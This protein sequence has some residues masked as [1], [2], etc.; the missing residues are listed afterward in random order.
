MKNYFKTIVL[1]V[2]MLGLT[3][4]SAAKKVEVSVNKALNLVNISL[5]SVSVGER[6]V[7]KDFDGTSLFRK[8]FRQISNF[9]KSFSLKEVNNGMYFVE[10]ENDSQIQITPVLKNDL[11]VTLI[12]KAAKFIFKPQY[13]K[14]GD[15]FKFS[16]LNTNEEAIKI[17]MYTENG[18]EF[19]KEE[20]VNDLIIKRTYSTKELP[21]GSYTLVIHKGKKTFSK[22][23]NVY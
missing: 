16:L 5:K 2:A 9:E 18:D 22:D 14:D 13:L 8:T 1:A 3:S 20:G 6:L 10:V 23:F 12:E 15:I 21:R 17:K 4:V 11:G 19:A 7:I